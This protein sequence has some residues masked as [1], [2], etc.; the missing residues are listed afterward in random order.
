MNIPKEPFVAH[1]GR[2]EKKHLARLKNLSGVAFS[3]LEFLQAF[4]LRTPTRND[5]VQ[6][7][8]AGMLVVN[9][10]AA[11]ALKSLNICSTHRQGEAVDGSLIAFGDVPMHHDRMFNQYSLLIPLFGKSGTL[12][13]AGENNLMVNEYLRVGLYALFDNWRPHSFWLDSESGYMVALCVGLK[14]IVKMKSTTHKTP[15]GRRTSDSRKRRPKAG[16][17]NSSSRRTEKQAAK[18]H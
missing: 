4:G 11:Y 8:V 2:Y 5:T 17:V 1:S 6:L 10:L 7:S 16:L 9:A 3:Q 18:I 14:T 12:S 13:I 15:D